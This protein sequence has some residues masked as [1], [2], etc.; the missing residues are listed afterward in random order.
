MP[1]GNFII[2]EPDTKEV[3]EKTNFTGYDYM[4]KFNVPYKNRV[5]YPIPA[6]ELFEDVCEQAGV[7]VGS[8]SFV[9]SNYM[10]LGNPFTNNEDCRTVVSNIAQLAGGFAKIGRDNKAY[11]KSLKNISSLLKVKDVNAMTVKD[12]NAT[13]V[14]LVSSKRDNADEALDGNNY[15]ED[16]SK[17]NQWG[18]INSLIL[19]VSGT[20]GENTTIQD[21]NSIAKNGL[22]EV[23]IED[24]YFL[25]NQ[26]EREKVI[27]PLWDSLKGIKYLPF[28]TEYYGYPYLDSGDLIYIQDT[29]DKGYISYVFN[30]TFTFNGGYSGKLET[31]AMTKTQTAYKNTMNGKTKF[32][33][34]ERRID[35]ING[36][37]LDVIEEQTETSQKL[38]QVEQTV[39]GITQ[40]VDAKYDYI[41]NIE[42]ANE[43]KLEN[44]V[45][46]EGYVTEFKIK[47]STLN[48]KYLA[49]S[50]ELVPSNTLVPL[51]GHF[52]IV[53]DKQSRSNM[54]NEAVSVD[55]ILDE[56]LRN[57]GEVYDELNI[58]DGKTTVI[59][60]IGVNEDL[61]L[62]VLDNETTETLKNTILTTFEGDTYIYIK[63]Y[64]GL[65]YTAK[66]MIK[67]DY[68]DKFITKMEANSKIEAKA[69]SIELSVNKKLES[70]S[71]TEETE[72]FVKLETDK[73][74]ETVSK[75]YA[76]KNEL[77]EERS[78]RIQTANEITQTVSTKVGKDEVISEINQSAEAVTINANKVNLS[79]YVTA[80]NLKTAG[81]TTIN[82]SN[83]TTGTI[84]ASRVNVTNINANNIKSGTI[85]ASKVNVTNINASNIKSGTIT[86]RTISGGKI[87]GT[88]IT[89]GN[90]FKVDADGNMN[91]SNANITGGKLKINGGTE[92]NP[93]MEIYNGGYSTKILP[94]HVFMK[95]NDGGLYINTY[96]ANK[97][98]YIY[99]DSTGGKITLGGKTAADITLN[100]G[101][102]PTITCYG[103]VQAIE[104]TYLSL[105]E[106]KKNIKEF[107]ETVLGM[108][109]NSQIYSF[110]YKIEE[111]TQ[112][113]HIGFII[114]DNYRTPKEII[115]QSGNSVD[116]YSMT[117]ILWKA[118]Q[119]QQ[120]I[121]ENL[122]RRL[123]KLEAIQNEKDNIQ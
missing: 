4:I 56:P 43:I 33:Q 66:Y 15:L 84:D 113:K 5:T 38:T 30:H 54:S 122:T 77:S 85:D 29:K 57:L 123:E 93:N 18:E 78:E 95:I 74:T 60:R 118:I 21:E 42:Q 65:S 86:G 106:K 83:I 26:A 117:S 10:I 80:T 119:E 107:N 111:N 104:H 53:C 109:K 96:D 41:R 87:T 114:G 75:N 71:T 49:P 34:I 79:G 92:V 69:D 16:F 108:I 100:S 61:S 121:I 67:N 17:N 37:I 101:T 47:G 6:G 1:F 48:F 27:N 23:I 36:V 3:K 115:S 39:D 11:I 116:N 91:C 58:V 76:T 7:E 89:N 97:H 12:L 50:N 72:A 82:G 110:N 35:K 62:Y 88:Q 25:I 9:N 99:A 51:G 103:E 94:E 105:E 32:R 102:N 70:Y 63:E 120:E 2:A 90:N 24:N 64:T 55:I 44:T 81:K 22:T 68:S 28:K 46:G 40:E 73:I 19:K 45:E 98:A 20:E 31:P 59:R 112:K 8:T 13:L 14:K 52:T